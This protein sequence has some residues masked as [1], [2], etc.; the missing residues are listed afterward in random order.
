[1]KENYEGQG[2]KKYKQIAKRETQMDVMPQWQHSCKLNLQ[3]DGR[4]PTKLE[5]APNNLL[6]AMVNGTFKD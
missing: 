6:D 5:V 1:M 3:G 2:N 4:K